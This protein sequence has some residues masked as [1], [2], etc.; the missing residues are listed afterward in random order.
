[1]LAFDQ[2]GDT[3]PIRVAIV[4][5]RAEFRESFAQLVKA[6]P[7]MQLIGTA[8]SLAGGLALLERGP[9]DVLLVDL[10]LPDGSG[11]D[12]IRNAMMRWPDCDAMV[13]SVFADQSHVMAALEAGATGYLL[14][15]ASPLDLTRQIRELRAGGSPISPVIARRLLMRLAPS[16]TTPPAEAMDPAVLLTE[17]EQ[18]VLQ[19]AAKG[20]SYEEVAGLLGISRH[21][22]M[23][24]VKRSYRKLQVHSK[25]QAIHEARRL[26]LVLD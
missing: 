12:L 1:M 13:I 9:I 21:T 8:A 17:Q 14:K 6:E 3:M 10:G 5:D 11:I 4:E 23:T 2:A 25:T 18:S 20:Y 7:D 15:D 16:M 24:Y 26:G 19:Y 22:V